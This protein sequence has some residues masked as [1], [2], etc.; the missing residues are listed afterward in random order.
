MKKTITLLTLLSIMLSVTAQTVD[1][2]DATF[3]QLYEEP[4]S[5]EWMTKLEPYAHQVSN[6]VDNPLSEKVYMLYPRMTDDDKNTPTGKKLKDLLLANL[7]RDPLR[8]QPAIDTDFKDLEGN[9]HKLADYRGKYVLLDFWASWCRPCIMALPEIRSLTEKY[10]DK[11]II[12]SIN[13]DGDIDKW[14]QV[15]EKHNISWTNLSDGGTDHSGIFTQ[16]MGVGIPYFILISPDGNVM[17]RWEGYGSDNTYIEKR[18]TR[19]MK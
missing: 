12:V 19:Y 2:N 3:R 10:K 13:L 15:A 9:A 17:V 14:R 5:Q 1:M 4:V 7:L 8:W 16:Y 18:I 11:L 6:D